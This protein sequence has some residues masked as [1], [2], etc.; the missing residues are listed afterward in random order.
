MTGYEISIPEGATL[1]EAEIS[2]PAQ[3]AAI[4]KGT[5]VDGGSNADKTYPMGLAAGQF[6]TTNTNYTVTFAVTDGWLKITPVAITI[7]A[8]DKTKVYGAADP[9]LTATVTGVPAN[10]VAPVYRLSCEEGQ[11]AGEYAITVTADAAANKNYT[12]SVEGGTFTIARRRVTLTS[13]N[14]MKWYDGTPLRNQTVTVGGDGFAA[15]EGATYNVTGA[16]TEAGTSRNNFT[17]T[18]NANTK[19]ANYQ[20]TLVFG[21]LRILEDQIEEDEVPLASLA[22]LGNQFGECFE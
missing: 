4:A 21:T 3:T 11:D 9:E 22:G 12:V 10:G 7:K 19:A 14:A 15:G 8:D 5:D 1:T 18:L 2:G 6:S 17:Y 20:I 16:Q 13:A